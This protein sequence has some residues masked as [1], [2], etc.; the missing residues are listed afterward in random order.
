MSTK[1]ESASGALSP[2]IEEVVL[3][4]TLKEL[5]ATTIRSL[6]NGE[7]GDL[8]E[9]SRSIKTTAEEVAASK[10]NL[11]RLPQ[12]PVAQKQ[13]Q[14]LL[15]ELRQQSSFCR[16]MLRRWRRSI[17]LRQQ[18]LDLTSGGSSYCEALDLSWSRRE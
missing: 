3:L 6:S 12:T 5:L 2:E 9:V 15:D 11:C 1:I 7:T 10:F 18:L 14:R 8:V 4:E 13:R 17:L 16:A